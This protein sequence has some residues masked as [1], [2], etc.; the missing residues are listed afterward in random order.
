MRDQ[1]LYMHDH[2]IRPNARF[3]LAKHEWGSS[4]GQSSTQETR[5]TVRPFIV[6]TNPKGGFPH[7]VQVR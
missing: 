6:D 3:D 5:L 7:H 1:Y 2:D 4:I